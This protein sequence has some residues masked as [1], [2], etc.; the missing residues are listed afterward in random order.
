MTDIKKIIQHVI[1]SL[2]NELQKL[3]DRNALNWHR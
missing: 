3:A 1:T 2:D